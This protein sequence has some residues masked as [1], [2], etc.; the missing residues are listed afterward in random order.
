MIRN[1]LTQGFVK[2]CFDYD[3]ITGIFTWR[4]R[5]TSHFTSDSYAAR[6]NKRCAGRIVGA[7][8]R[9]KGYPTVNIRGKCYRLHRLAFL[10][11]NGRWPDG[12]VDHINHDREDNRW[13]NLREVSRR[14]NCR[15]RSAD[16]RSTSG[17]TGVSWFK[18]D[19]KWRAQLSRGGKNTHIGYYDTPEDAHAAYRA[20]C[21]NAGYHAN[22][23]T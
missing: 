20:A 9:Q 6:M 7:R 2:E 19:K 14:E 3:Q 12:D 10:W 1:D 16:G 23:G 4:E 17:L 21:A 8:A 15:N 11:M 22:H 5:P 18:R 13:S